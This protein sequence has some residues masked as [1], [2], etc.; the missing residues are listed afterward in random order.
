MK[1][2]RFDKEHLDHCKHSIKD[3]FHIKNDLSVPMLKK[4]VLSVSSKDVISDSNTIDHIYEELFLISG[5]KPLKLLAKKSIATFKLR[6]G[7]V[8]GAKVTLRRT[9]MYD[10]MRRFVNIALPRA[11][12]FIGFSKKQLDGKGNLSVGV[13]EQI[14]FP[15]IDYN[16]IN[17]IRGLNISMVTNTSSD[18]VATS[19]FTLLGIPFFDLTNTNHNE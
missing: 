15:E 10:F 5:Q 8:I 16:K 12:D 11:R 14:I 4:I 17:K 2:F 9:M 6:K 1:I 7:M 3:K 18:E 13:K 19:L